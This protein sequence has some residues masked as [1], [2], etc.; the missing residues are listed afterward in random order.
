MSS[1]RRTGSLGCESRMLAPIAAEQH[2]RSDE[3][4]QSGRVEEAGVGEVDHDVASAL[5]VHRATQVGEIG[6]GR[7]VELAAHAQGRRARRSVERRARDPGPSPS[8][9]PPR[10]L[11]PFSRLTHAG[12]T[13][14][15]C[16]PALP[17]ASAHET[18]DGR[19]GR[20]PQFH[21]VRGGSRAKKR[22]ERCHRKHGARNASVSTSTSSTGLEERGRSRTS[23]RRSRP[24]R[25][26]RSGPARRG[27]GVE[28]DLDRRHLLGSQGGL[29]SHRGPGGRTRDQLYYGGAEEGHQGPLHDEQGAARAGR[30]PLGSSRPSPT[31]QSRHDHTY[32]EHAMEQPGP[33]STSVAEIVRLSVPGSLEYV[34][35]VR[36]TAATVAAR[37]RVRRRGDRGHPCRGRRARQRRDRSRQRWRDRVHV[38]ESG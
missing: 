32:E 5:R 37:S 1:S 38:L 36:L 18:C 12:L 33:S 9:R 31:R 28:P 16:A 14:K 10:A 17:E 24:A 7:H 13:R 20:V 21:S 29:R 35:V 23:P 19:F 8:R 3:R 2:V 25:S 30:R 11:R 6:R 4:A 26:T 22:R 34:R 15:V 27:E